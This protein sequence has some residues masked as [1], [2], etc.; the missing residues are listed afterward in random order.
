MFFYRLIRN[1]SAPSEIITAALSFIIVIVFSV[2]VHE[3]SHGFA[4]LKNGDPTAK[5]RGRLTLN[6]LVHF[7]LMG[8]VM[9]LLAGF[10]WAKPVPVDAR[11]FKNYKVGMLTV[12]IAGVAANLLLAGVFLL[13]LYIFA[14][15]LYFTQNA[16]ALL[17]VLQNIA[18]FI[19]LYG[20]QIN[21]MLALFNLLPIYP[22]DGYNLVSTL[23]PR[24]NKFQFFMIR[25][26]FF[27]LIG[28]ILI[29]Q[30]GDMLGFPYLN[31]FGL[32]SDLITNLIYKVIFA[33]LGVG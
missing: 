25:Y 30:L 18:G 13:L 17:T 15:Y 26:G 22:L 19:I 23:L 6:P 11:N 32:F 27:V 9:F 20:V 29:G 2:M 33:S 21:F 3:I 14:P 10:G 8:V 28:L 4:A 1:G 31:I 24:N 12:S 7:D 5:E 16:N